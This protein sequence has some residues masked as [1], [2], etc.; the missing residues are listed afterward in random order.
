MNYKLVDKRFDFFDMPTEKPSEL[1]LIFEDIFL[2]L[3]KQFSSSGKY[4]PYR[5]SLGMKL[6]K[7]K[8]LVTSASLYKQLARLLHFS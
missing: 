4:L 6:V 1:R 7:K 8:Y 3:A 5:L 2:K